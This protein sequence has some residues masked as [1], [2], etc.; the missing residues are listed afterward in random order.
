MAVPA[1]AIL[2]GFLFLMTCVK[3]CKAFNFYMSVAENFPQMSFHYDTGFTTKEETHVSFGSSE[4]VS[5]Q[6]LWV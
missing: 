4:V 6:C 1:T 3:L 5:I 2:Y